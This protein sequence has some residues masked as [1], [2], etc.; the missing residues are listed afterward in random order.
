[1]HLV[2]VLEGPVDY[3]VG[4]EDIATVYSDPATD[5]RDVRSSAIS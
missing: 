5:G 3:D 2:H 1:M 4:P